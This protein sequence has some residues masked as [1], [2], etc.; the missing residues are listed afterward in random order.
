MI[1]NTLNMP[2]F[3]LLPRRTNKT[4]KPISY[5]NTDMVL[6]FGLLPRRIMLLNEKLDPNEGQSS[7]DKELPN[8][9]MP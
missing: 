3:G 7:M 1:T 5:M 9:A 4:L 6:S 2:R 8:F